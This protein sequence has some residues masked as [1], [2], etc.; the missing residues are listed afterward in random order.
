MINNSEYEWGLVLAGGGGKGAYQAG[1]F[2]ALAE[3]GYY[4]YVTD[5][6]GS[7]VGALN[8]VLFAYNDMNV[9]ESVWRDISPRQFLDVDTDMI[10]MKEG[11]VN[12]NGLLDIISNYIDLEKISSGP[13]RIVVTVTEYDENGNGEGT[14]RYFSLNGKDKEEI[15]QLLLA[16]SALPIIYS[17]VEING[18][19]YR[20]GG[21]K[22]NMPIEPLYIDGIR[23]FIVVGLSDK[24]NSSCEK[25][26]D[27]DFI[28]I[29]PEKN[30]GNFFDG[31]LDF[32]SKGARVRMEIGY[33]DA[34]RV[35]EFEGKD[36]L[37]VAVQTEYQACVE[38]D[39]TKVKY[40]YR[41]S[42]M[43]TMVNNDLDKINKLLD[44]FS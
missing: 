36:M 14:A 42:E 38:R 44:Q 32:S 12:R 28:F 19:K 13:I 39:Y 7:S 15:K 6:A 4:N 29:K 10:D 17:P 9:T 33:M 22:N 27:A 43:D 3:K 20:D 31:T 35:L 18:K 30:I 2:R 40:E 16:S 37:D 21:L 11:I 26:P 23:K 41:R 34:I 1:V 8:A 24:A 5:V 25:Y